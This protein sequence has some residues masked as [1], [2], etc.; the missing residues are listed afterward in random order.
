MCCCTNVLARTT[1]SV[2]TPNRRRSNPGTLYLRMTSLAIGTVLLTGFDMMSVQAVG[3]CL[4]IFSA[5]LLTM[6]ALILN[7]SSRVIPGLRGMP[8]G[9]ITMSVPFKHCGSW[10]SPL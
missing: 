5:R 1:S 8:A 10:A 9:I 3:Q 6:P 2:V 7:R 4:A